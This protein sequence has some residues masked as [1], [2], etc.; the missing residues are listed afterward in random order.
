MKSP[1]NFSDQNNVMGTGSSDVE[2]RVEK[3]DK[4]LTKG[5]RESHKLTKLYKKYKKFTNIMKKL[6]SFMKFWTKKVLMG[7]INSVYA[8]MYDTR[9]KKEKTDAGLPA[10][11]ICWYRDVY[12]RQA[13]GASEYFIV[14]HIFDLF[15]FTERYHIYE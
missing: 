4:K 9:V 2:R 10:R 15:T 11:A 8:I 14:D 3:I 5:N 13:A 6:G 12:K 1:K 7:I